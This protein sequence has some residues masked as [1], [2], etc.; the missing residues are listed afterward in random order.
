MLNVFIYDHESPG[1]KK[2]KKKIYFSYSIMT[3]YLMNNMVYVLDKIIEVLETANKFNNKVKDFL[4]V[5][6]QLPLVLDPNNTYIPG[7]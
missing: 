5:R 4:V 1:K 2:K 7:S 6:A 3:L